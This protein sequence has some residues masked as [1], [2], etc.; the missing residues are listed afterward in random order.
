MTITQGPMTALP[1]TR[2]KPSPAA[3]LGWM[4]VSTLILA[5]W[6]GWGM[7]WMWA[8]GAVVGVFVHEYG[9]VLVMDAL[10]CGPAKIRIIPF[11]GGAATPARPPTTEFRDVLI[12]LAGPAFGLLAVL[13]FYAAA[14][15]TQDPMWLGAALAVAII[16]LLNLVP[17]PPLD[18]SRAL[19]PVLARIHP[20]VERGV[21][22]LIGA[23]VVF[24]AIQH[25]QLMIGL[26]VGLSVLGALKRPTVR[27]MAIKLSGA[28]PVW[29]VL[30]YLAAVAACLGVLGY[31]LGLMD[32]PTDPI[33][34][35]HRFG[36]G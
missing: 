1:P 20:Q 21:L 3:E 4:L 29:S 33:R 19:G 17:A 13:P 30:L 27:P 8:L 14:G 31:T 26:F 23:G 15:I 7:G 10:G 22:I 12:S 16:N 6:L 28:E 35:L 25:H 32:L 24:W 34:L 11:L 2:P 9:H 18:G 5:V 36:I